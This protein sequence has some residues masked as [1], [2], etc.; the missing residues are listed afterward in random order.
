M[1]ALTARLDRYFE[2]LIDANAPHI[3]EATTPD[4]FADS[5]GA[6]ARALAVKRDLILE[7][8]QRIPAPA[9]AGASVGSSSAPLV[10]PAGD[11]GAGIEVD[12]ALAP[13]MEATKE[14]RGART[15]LRLFCFAHTDDDRRCPELAVELIDGNPFCRACAWHE[16]AC[17]AQMESIEAAR[18]AAF[19]GSTKEDKHAAA[20]R[21][22]SGALPADWRS[23]AAGS[24]DHRPERGRD[25][26][27]GPDSDDARGGVDGRPGRNDADGGL[28]ELAAARPADPAAGRDDV[29]DRG[30]AARKDASRGGIAPAAPEIG[31]QPKVEVAG[32]AAESVAESGE[33]AKG[34][35][36]AAD[37]AAAPRSGS[38][39]RCKV[40]GAIW[41]SPGVKTVVTKHDC[42][43][44]DLEPVARGGEEADP[45][46][47]K[48]GKRG[49]RTKAKS[50]SKS[51][52][53]AC[54]NPGCTLTG[55]VEHHNPATCPRFRPRD[56]VTPKPE[57]IKR[58][59]EL[60]AK[61]D[62]GSA[63]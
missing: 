59:G 34:E 1:D 37:G 27:A 57:G 20:E 25:G 49:V 42:V 5:V 12:E 50:V 16:L 14:L 11:A 28:L 7:D 52:T 40:C 45:P 43:V 46:A 56:P 47:P 51:A 10:P 29:A 2:Q 31:A 44:A 39:Q 62:E 15:S 8:L 17:I 61:Y 26:D 13:F 30:P 3:S 32:H 33:I 24:D 48:T 63:T 41:I 22:T 58:A 23:A 38:D 4:A 54:G 53:V 60:A 21:G 55:T 19:N 6:F 18:A 36:A 35:V 9:S